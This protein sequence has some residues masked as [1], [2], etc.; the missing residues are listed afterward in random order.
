[1]HQ[2]IK[3]KVCIVLQFLISC[4][5]SCTFQFTMI[6]IVPLSTDTDPSCLGLTRFNVPLLKFSIFLFIITTPLSDF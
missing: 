1:M 4:T 6:R 2:N 5:R 3:W